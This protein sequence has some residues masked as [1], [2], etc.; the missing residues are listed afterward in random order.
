MSDLRTLAIKAILFFSLICILSCLSSQKVKSFTIEEFQLYFYDFQSFE[1]RFLFLRPK[2]KFPP[3]YFLLRFLFL[4]DSTKEKKSLRSQRL[5]KFCLFINLEEQ[6]WNWLRQQRFYYYQ[7]KRECCDK[8]RLPSLEF[9]E[10][11]KA[12]GR[13]NSKF[14]LFVSFSFSWSLSYP[15]HHILCFSKKTPR[16]FF[17]FLSM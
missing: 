3:E 12:F 15:S 16:A 4:Q 8:S 13:I 14:S 6:I 10:F 5:R 1:C 17:C 7:T 11:Y 2:S 9:L